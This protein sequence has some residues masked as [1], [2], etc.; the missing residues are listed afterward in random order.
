MS[1]RATPPNGQGLLPLCGFILAATCA[2]S[3]ISVTKFHVPST[4]FN[5]PRSTA[6]MHFLGYRHPKADHASSQQRFGVTGQQGSQFGNGSILAA[7]NP[8]PYS[9]NRWLASSTMTA[10]CPWH[11]SE[12]GLFHPTVPH[13]RYIVTGG[14]GFIGSHLVH[15][16][17]AHSGPGQVKIIDN[18]WRG[19]MDRL[20]TRDEWAVVPQSDVCILDLRNEA[21]ASKY[22]RG[23]DFVYHLADVVVGVNFV[24][25]HQLS[26]FHDNVLINTNTLKA[27]KQ[28]KIPN[29]I[30]AGTACSYPQHLQMGPG[31]HA[32]REDQKYPADPESSYGWSKLM[33]EYE[34]QLA[35]SSS[36]NVGILRF[37]NVYGPKSDSSAK[38]GQVIP[39]LLRKA[40]NFTREEFVVWGSGSQ[41]RDF[42]YVSD[43]VEALLL[44]KDKGMNKGVIEIGSGHATTV[45][46][47][48]RAIAHV[49]GAASGT[50]IPVKF[51]LSMPEG[52]RGRIAASER[53][54]VILG[55][56]PKVRIEDGLQATFSWIREQMNKP[57]VLVVVNGQ[58][59][60]GDLA[61]KSLH[62]HV[63]QPNNAHLATYLT[64]VG[65]AT[66]QTLL[67]RMAHYTWR[68]PEPPNGDYGTWVDE[69]A[70]LCPHTDGGEWPQLCDYDE[71]KPLWGGSLT[72]C[73][74]HVSKSGVHL[75]YRWHIHQ[76]IMALNLHHQYDYI[77]YTRAD[78]LYLCDHTSP[79]TINGSQVWVPF[80][81]EY[82]GYTDRHV[83]GTGSIMLEALN[84][85]QEIVCRSK[86]YAALIV[87]AKTNNVEQLQALVWKN[88]GLEV[89]QFPFVAFTVRSEG[90]PASWT[91]GDEHHELSQ[92]GVR[93][94]YQ[95]ELN[96]AVKHCNVSSLPQAMEALRLHRVCGENSECPLL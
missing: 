58:P 57:N 60:G 20:Q 31:V 24:F 40:I 1:S 65:N 11:G 62:K 41:H 29:Y 76:K 39:S 34:A 21:D 77:I 8:D 45:K 53:A 67:E 35:Q 59:R 89:G 68:L 18:F 42:V 44:V 38:T 7:D 9:A 79:A 23:A 43:I 94:K 30:Y 66:N 26:V 70:E 12:H 19:R 17:A 82:G 75:G 13:P 49:V 32:L 83:V 90:D 87:P 22:L 46:E 56:R 86:H 33:G 96:D 71:G 2:L 63:L 36:F 55:W 51:D 4:P 85:T 47:L 6:R 80:G 72:R 37:H 52:D 92:F 27:C 69:A 78:Y 16:L 73:P 93:V 3:Y 5:P 28:N 48:A 81:E 84:I 91:P 64:P 61:W 54:R 74:K 15:Q 10:E 14:A 25:G 95:T 50:N 88:I